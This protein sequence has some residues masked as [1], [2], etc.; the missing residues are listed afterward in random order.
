[1]CMRYNTETLPDGAYSLAI[2]LRVL[3]VFTTREDTEKVLPLS[4]SKHTY[5]HLES[6]F[7][8][9][10]QHNYFEQLR[11][12]LDEKVP[13]MAEMTSVAPT[14]ISK[15]LLD[16]IKRPVDLISYVNHRENFSTLVLRELCRSV[17][18]P[19]LSD[20]IRMFVVPALAEFKD[21]PYIQ[22]IVC[23]N[24]LQLV[25]TINLLYCILS[26]DS[27]NQFCKYKQK[28]LLTLLV[29][30]L[31]QTNKISFSFLDN[32]ES[33]MYCLMFLFILIIFMFIY[34]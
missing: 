31:P 6:I 24:R 28:A 10:I 20:P 18:S 17:F 16:M 9:L 1:M 2:P 30:I 32:V 8:Y 29:L 19:R 14:P 26:L 23:I 11:K 21:L 4:A 34:L 27:S 12:L 13:P 7:V 33:F 22:L 3:E 5:R 15:C 25:P